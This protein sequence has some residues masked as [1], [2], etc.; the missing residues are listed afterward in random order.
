MKS[1]NHN[2][3]TPEMKATYKKVSA[4]IK[5]FLLKKHGLTVVRKPST[6]SMS[7]HYCLHMTIDPDQKALAPYVTIKMQGLRSYLDKNGEVIVTNEVIAEMVRKL[8]HAVPNVILT[9]SEKKPDTVKATFLDFSNH[10]FSAARPSSRRKETVEEDVLVEEST[11]PDDDGT[12]APFSSKFIPVS[13][14]ATAPKPFP[15][16]PLA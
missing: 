3:A 6:E 2:H 11:F 7:H 10:T 12:V 4:E 15:R 13:N 5:A 1:L 8:A 14:Y 9:V 16:N